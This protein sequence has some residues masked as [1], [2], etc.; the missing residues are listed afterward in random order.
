M[1]IAGGLLG[2]KRRHFNP[3]DEYGEYRDWESELR[4][5]EANEALNKN[6]RAVARKIVSALEECVGNERKPK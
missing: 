2:H 6:R 4:A 1:R 3:K 5:E